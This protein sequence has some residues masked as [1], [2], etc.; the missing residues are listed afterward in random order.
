[1]KNYK[2]QDGCHNCISCFIKQDYDDSDEYYCHI[3]KSKRPLCGSVLMKECFLVDVDYT[4]DNEENEIL[5]KKADKESIRRQD[6]WDK[7]AITRG[8]SSWGIC[9]KWKK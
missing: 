1:M 8:V 3:D 4:D 2:E 5:Q 6:A 7:W 9:D